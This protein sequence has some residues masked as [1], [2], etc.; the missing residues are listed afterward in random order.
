MAYK[1][2]SQKEAR[3]FKAEISR[4]QERLNRLSYTQP[5]TLVDNTRLTRDEAIRAATAIKLG[6]TL[7]LKPTTIWD[8]FD[9]RAV[10]P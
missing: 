8:L 4:L 7:L 10:K 6:F 1:H 3:E 5:G 9:I 2:I